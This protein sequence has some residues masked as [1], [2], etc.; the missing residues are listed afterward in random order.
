MGLGP[1]L[2]FY[3]IS[4]KKMT[5]MKIVGHVICQLKWK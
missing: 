3:E 1:D 5:N 2:Y 4:L